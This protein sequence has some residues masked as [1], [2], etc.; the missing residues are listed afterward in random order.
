M[1]GH[2]HTGTVHIHI[3]GEMQMKGKDG[4]SNIETSGSELNRN[5]IE[6]QR[7]ELTWS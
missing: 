1:H 7:I 5:Q 6:S 2:T 4:V 3:C